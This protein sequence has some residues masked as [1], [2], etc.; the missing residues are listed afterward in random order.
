M[1][2]VWFAVIP[3]ESLGVYRPE[4]ELGPERDQKI[5]LPSTLFPARRIAVDTMYELGALSL[6][7]ASFEMV[8]GRS[9]VKS[10]GK[11]PDWLKSIAICS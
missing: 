8:A 5:P 9:I 4:T 7:E 6:M 11:V 10:W 1:R 3:E 2:T